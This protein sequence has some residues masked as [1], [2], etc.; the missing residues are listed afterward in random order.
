[1]RS[2]LGMVLRS[3]LGYALSRTPYDFMCGSWRVSSFSRDE[4]LAAIV[5]PALGRSIFLHCKDSS[6]VVSAGTL[7]LEAE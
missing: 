4:R 1:M 6:R 3:H 5:G 7:S 2:G